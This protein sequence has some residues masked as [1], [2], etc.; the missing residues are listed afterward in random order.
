MTKLLQLLEQGELVK[1]IFYK[2]LLERFD[3]RNFHLMKVLMKNKQIC[4]AIQV[5]YELTNQNQD[6]E[7][8]SLI[9]VAEQYKIKKLLLITR[10]QEEIKKIKGYKIEIVKIE[11]WLLI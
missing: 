1:L 10:N 5:C 2:D 6:R 8:N 4:Q 3:L 7:I 9:E 11:K